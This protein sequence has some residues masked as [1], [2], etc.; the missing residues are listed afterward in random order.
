MEFYDWLHQILVVFFLLPQAHCMWFWV[1]CSAWR[2]V[3]L[4]V[5]SSLG[6]C[7][8][9]QPNDCFLLSISV[10]LFYRFMTLDCS[11]SVVLDIYQVLLPFLFVEQWKVSMLLELLWVI[12][13]NCYFLKLIFVF[14][15]WIIQF[16]LSFRWFYVCIRWFIALVFAA[17]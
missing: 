17:E 4:R 16:V 10:F 9:H 7:A 12:I 5:L 14:F 11:M 2:F 15:F 8:S 6:R 13:R 1:S 3:L